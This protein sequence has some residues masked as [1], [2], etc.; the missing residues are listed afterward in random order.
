MALHSTYASKRLPEGGLLVCYTGAMNISVLQ[1]NIWY[2]EDIQ[3]IV[4]FLKDHPADVICLQELTI[5]SN[6][7]TVKN[8]P[9]YVANELGY[10]YYCKELP[11]ESTDGET[12]MLANGIFSR[13]PITDKKF[14]WINQ[15]KEAGGYDDEYRAYVEVTLDAKGTQFQVGT[16]HMSYTH[17]F[18]NTPNKQQETDLL[19]RQLST[20]QKSFVFTGDL[21]ATPSSYTI[22][23]IERVLVNAGPNVNNKTWATKP[24][25]YNG[26]EETELKWRLDY[27][28]TSNGVEVLSSEVL[29]T[30]YSDHLPL[31]TKLVII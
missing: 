13:F 1:W 17:R 6:N 9:E 7:Q 4:G 25:S 29:S 27:V 12:M 28:F 15:P 10:N 14:V 26:F 11:I 18:E 24:F 30:E 2:Q 16:T 20:H 8:T 5:N 31:L 19:L 21:N 3:N 22:E 23:S